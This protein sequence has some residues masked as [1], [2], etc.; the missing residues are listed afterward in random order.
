VVIVRDDD[1]TLV[2]RKDRTQDIK[3]IVQKLKSTPELERF[4]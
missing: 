2:V 1:V 3:K 4:V